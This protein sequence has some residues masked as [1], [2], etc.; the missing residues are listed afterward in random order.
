MKNNFVMLTGKVSYLKDIVFN[1]ES[2]KEIGLNV[3]NQIFKVFVKN[4]FIYQCIKL[5]NTIMCSGFLETNNKDVFIVV[6]KCT[7]LE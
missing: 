1:K 3:N 4:D 2:L 5:E 6:D 7:I